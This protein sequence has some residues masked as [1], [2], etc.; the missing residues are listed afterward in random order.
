[1]KE[2]I[3]HFSKMID[4]GFLGVYKR[5]K[6]SEENVETRFVPAL[7]KACAIG[8]FLNL[9]YELFKDGKG[10]L[11]ETE[12]QL[13]K[14]FELPLAEIINLLPQRYICV[15]VENSNYYGI[16][17]LIESTGNGKVIITEDGYLMLGESKLCASKDEI[18]QIG[19]YNGQLIYEELCKGDYVKN[20][21]FLED[22]RNVY[23]SQN[24]I[25]QSEEQSKFIKAYPELFRMCFDK[26]TRV[27][28]YRCKRCGM[29]LRENRIGVF[30]C[31]SK[32]CNAQ[33]EEKIKIEM[34]D[35]GWVM[36]DIAARN[37]Y[38]PGQ[39]EQKI[40]QILE[41][42]KAEGTVEKY[43]LWPGKY[44]GRYDTWDFMVN[45]SNGRILVIDA[46]DVE[47]PHWII[48]DS[49]EYLEGADFIY[50]VPDD[51]T[52][53]Y[54]NQI[55]DHVSCRGKIQCLRVKELKKLIGVK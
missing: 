2:F 45:M 21:Q 8:V 49:R 7:T 38:Y 24:A 26:N 15:I 41:A 53:I 50:V 13:F 29:V 34:H 33:L 43:T 47:H 52:K 5:Q 35:P 27:E 54:V 18:N 22:K 55:N 25:A 14:M 30:S 23:I 19:E 6:L 42:G 3:E 12:F 39:L 48:T 10:I 37:I 40:K 32:K 1:M 4:Y 11:P 17:A 31:V 46:K 16:P 28:L 9:K 36:N 20:R 51:K 44:E